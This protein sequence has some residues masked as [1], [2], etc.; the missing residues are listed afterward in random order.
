MSNSAG[1]DDDRLGDESDDAGVVDLT[2]RGI[3]GGEAPGGA[4]R[5]GAAPDASGTTAGTAARAGWIGVGL[6]LVSVLAYATVNALL[7]AV[8]GEIDPFVGA[9]LRQLPLLAAM[10]IGALVLRPV[11]MRPRHAEF[12]GHRLAMGIFAAGFVALF[13]GNAILFWAFEWVGLGVST[14]GYLGGLLLGSALMSWMIGE[15][16]TAWQFV[17]MGGIALGLWF[18]AQ[19]AAGGGGDTWLAVLGLALA[20]TTG[21][22]YAVS[23]QASR[24]SQRRP[25][26]FI[27]TLGMLTVGGVLSL[28]AFLLVRDGFDLA[29]TFGPVT[30]FQWTTVL[31]AGVV[32]GIALIAVTLALRFTTSTTVSMINSLVIVLGVVFG[33]VFFGEPVTVSLAI[34]SALILG[35]VAV[36]QLRGRRRRR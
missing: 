17:G 26:R 4:T 13:V 1:R 5:A 10:A 33:L 6:G 35:G 24:I 12:I 30:S 29:A 19:S 16:P 21:V 23:N 31:L 27:A 18:T 7:R 36:G 14:A 25:G 28:F 20:V 2:G 9:L 15:R 22:C 8:A 11:A 32:N 3:V 34:G